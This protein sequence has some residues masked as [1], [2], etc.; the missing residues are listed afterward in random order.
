MGV[1]MQ[2]LI[3][4]ATGFVGQEVVRKIRA[5]GHSASILARDPSSPSAAKLESEFGAHIRAGDILDEDSLSEAVTGAEVVIHL[6]G[7][8]SEAG[9]QTFER[10]HA[11]G[12][13]NLLTAA[14][15]QGV[16][17][18]VH[19]SA[20][21]TRPD[22][23]SRYHKSKWAAE[24]AVRKSGLGF[25]IFRPS[26]IYGRGDQ[27]VNLFARLMRLSPL[28]PVMG[29]GCRQ[30]QPVAVEKVA[31]CF[32]K[33]LGEDRSIGQTYDVCGPERLTFNELLDTIGEVIG[34]KRWKLH[35]PLGLARAQARL[36][37]WL[38]PRL[39]H[40]APPFNRDQLTMLEEGN[41]GN[42]TPANDLFHL[43]QES[44]RAGISR[45]LARGTSDSR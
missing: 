27:F 24:E 45:Y 37:E 18:F 26:L 31:E 13:L 29:S 17:R 11:A 28:V 7:V 8:I 20:L 41:I 25:S 39:L 6:V 22:A 1:G 14:R 33:A 3:T 19:M 9:A 30:F 12:T 40:R 36:L 4:G 43:R 44:F 32:S 10:V 38:F 16:K 2:V 15:R 42:P 35:V 21:G 23:V 34:R 5:A